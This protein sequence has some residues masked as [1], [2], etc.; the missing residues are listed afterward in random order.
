MDK[1]IVQKVYS[2]VLTAAVTF[3]AGFAL[4]KVWKLA[5]GAEPPDPED[6]EVPIRQAL[7]WFLASGVG[8]GVA[9][10]FLHR[11]MTQRQLKSLA[12]TEQASPD[13]INA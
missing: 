5:T 3:A 6:P 9:Q 11:T 12:T 7:I 13:Q 8:V 1:V 2:A 10:L 4:K